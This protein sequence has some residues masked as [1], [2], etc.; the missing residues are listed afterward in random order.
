MSDPTR[1]VD[2]DGADD[3]A[4]LERALLR[5]GK[6]ERLP[7][8][9]R[10]Q[11]WLGLAAQIATPVAPP[12]HGAP[13]A[14]VAGA[15][16]LGVSAALKGAI[17]A[18][19]LGAGSIAGYRAFRPTAA[20]LAPAEVAV[21]RA[22]PEAVAPPEL[23]APHKPALPA[24]DATPAARR[25]APSHL[26]AEGRVVLEARAALR[27]GRPEDALRVLEPARAEFAGG[28]L[29]QEREALTIEA[30][31]KTG[32]RADASRRAD[33]FLRAYPGSPHATAV[34][35]FAAP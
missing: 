25:P 4:A 14:T 21:T 8:R 33:A 20:P 15:K 1:L 30:L 18:V 17:V 34:R 29:V 2:G 35:S 27:D 6:G 31:A 5:A 32:R 23:A 16:A 11:I 19:A 13:A 10:D 12:G 7:S 9:D 26:A 22:P 3:G 24:R 28:A